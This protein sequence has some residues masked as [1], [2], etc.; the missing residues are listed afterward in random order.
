MKATF[1]LVCL[2][3][4]LGLALAYPS[5]PGAK[6]S[7]NSQ[8]RRQVC[9]IGRCGPLSERDDICDQPEDCLGEQDCFNQRCT[10][11]PGETDCSPL[12][13]ESPE[14]I[15][16]TTDSENCGTCGNVCDEGQ[17][18]DNG[19]CKTPSCSTYAGGDLVDCCYDGDCPD[20]LS[21][22][23]ACDIGDFCY[24][25]R[26]CSEFFANYDDFESCCFEN[27]CPPGLN[28]NT[29]CNTGYGCFGS[30]KK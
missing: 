14:C 8:C 3:V 17:T 23:D 2:F 22:S 4:V 29:A 12:G 7:S 11:C 13:S 10:R 9:K 30:S 18:C 21:S 16:T 25:P 24:P 1:V 5:A 15:D 28:Q 19:K 6:C 27:I 20:G 26:S